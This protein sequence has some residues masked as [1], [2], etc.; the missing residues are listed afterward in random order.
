[1]SSPLIDEIRERRGL[2]YYVS[3]AAD[4]NELRA[5]S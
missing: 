5:S 4:V 1:M 2:V 3:C